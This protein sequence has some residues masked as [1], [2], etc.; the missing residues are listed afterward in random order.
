MD[1]LLPCFA[2]GFGSGPIRSRTL[3]WLAVP[4]SNVEIEVSSEQFERLFYYRASRCDGFL[5][6]VNSRS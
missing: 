4:L 2:T 3:A 5:R 6:I 1:S